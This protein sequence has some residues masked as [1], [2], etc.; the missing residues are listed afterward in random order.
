MNNSPTNQPDSPK[1]TK[2]TLS[3]PIGGMERLKAKY[4]ENPAK[5]KAEFAASGFDIEN[6]IFEK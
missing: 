1:K 3:L 2:I 6:I 5:V 4:L